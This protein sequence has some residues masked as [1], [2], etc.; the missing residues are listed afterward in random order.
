MLKVVELFGG[1]GAFTKA[2]ERLKISHKIED[3]VEID[4]YAVM[5]YNVIHRYNF[6][7]QD[8]TKY[9]KRLDV[10]IIMHGSPCQDFSIMG[11]EAGAGFNMQTR[12]SLMYR[13]L[14]IV[15]NNS[16]KVVI[17][18]NVKNLLSK[19]H[20]SNFNNYIYIM[21]NLG[22]NSYYKV[23]NAKDYGIPQNRERVFVISIRKDI[24]KGFSF[25]KP[26]NLDVKLKDLLED[27]SKID[28]KYYLS[29]KSILGRKNSKF[30]QYNLYK[31]LIDNKDIHP[32]ILSG[33]DRSPT[34]KKITTNYIE[35]EE[36][37]KLDIDCRAFKEE[38]I[39]GTICTRA[40]VNKVLSK[41]MIR[42]L[43]PLEITRLMGFDDIDY[44]KM[45]QVNSNTQIYKQLG[46]SIV[47]NVLEHIIL[48]LKKR[49]Y[50]DE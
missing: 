40:G 27:D 21:N 38:T 30:K 26:I 12:S 23:L 42:K 34:L 22:Y 19:N 24:D 39:S 37:G 3:Y 13:T 29:D 14:D 46:N 50:L 28:E 41:E 36:K 33:Y 6:K 25:P 7:P 5:S 8:I 31:S 35:W 9:N 2:L 20:I 18:E 44:Y 49:G 48:E 16:P 43:T 17:W 4:K 45:S 32:T 15:E 47:V 11:K 1:I 10:D